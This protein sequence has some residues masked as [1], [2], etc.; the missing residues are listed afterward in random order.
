MGLFIL[1]NQNFDVKPDSLIVLTNE[2][3]SM[4]EIAKKLKIS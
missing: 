3:Y 1:S 4:P 2:A